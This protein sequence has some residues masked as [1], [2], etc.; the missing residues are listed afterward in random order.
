MRN[1]ENTVAVECT[2]KRVILVLAVLAIVYVLFTLSLQLSCWFALVEA[3]FK[4]CALLTLI[5]LVPTGV[6]WG[7]SAWVLMQ[8]PPETFHFLVLAIVWLACFLACGYWMRRILEC[9]WRSVVTVYVMFNVSSNILAVA[10]ALLGLL[11]V[12]GFAGFSP[13]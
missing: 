2:F 1:L 13:Q 11:I 8:T 7:L 10:T 6:A 3:T 5:L 4:R 9:R 12:C